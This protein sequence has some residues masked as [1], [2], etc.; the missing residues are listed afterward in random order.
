[1]GVVI[2]C[3]NGGISRLRVRRC[4]MWVAVMGLVLGLAAGGASEARGQAGVSP[5]LDPAAA[6]EE[7]MRSFV[8]PEVRE[9]RAEVRTSTSREPSSAALRTPEPHPEPPSLP[10]RSSHRFSDAFVG[11]AI[12]ASVGIPLGALLLHASLRDETWRGQRCADS[13]PGTTDCGMERFGLGL[14]GVAVMAGGG[15]IGTVQSLGESGVPVYAAA[16]GGEAVLGLSG[17]ALG[18][19]VGLIGGHPT[20]RGLAFALPLAALGSA[21]GAFLHAR[22]GETQSGGG[23]QFRKGDWRLGIPDVRVNPSLHTDAGPSVRVTL[24]SAQF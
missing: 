17:Y 2:D 9:L 13:D 4:E 23:L 19:Q 12:G 15:P 11:A 6:M 3:E 1:M 14:L 16:L 18:R 22:A 10:Q 7:T 5:T 20:V 21:A 24:V 8:A